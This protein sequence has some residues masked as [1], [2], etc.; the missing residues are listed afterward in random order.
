MKT[1][2]SLFKKSTNIFI[3]KAKSISM[4]QWDVL[5]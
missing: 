5:S 2:D 3:I 4:S 1:T